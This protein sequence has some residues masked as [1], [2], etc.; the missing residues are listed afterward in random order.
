MLLLSINLFKINLKT[1]ILEKKMVIQT[2][3][4][5]GFKHTAMLWKRIAVQKT[6][7]DYIRYLQGPNSY[8]NPFLGTLPEK[9]LKLQEKKIRV[10]Q[11]FLAEFDTFLKNTSI[12]IDE[13]LKN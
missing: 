1:V 13:L 5:F 2:R 10:Y 9:I 7:D 3:N 6:V 8:G 12:N 4:S 11:N